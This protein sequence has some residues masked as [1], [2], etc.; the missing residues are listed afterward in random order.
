M[1]LTDPSLAQKFWRRTDIVWKEIF[2]PRSRTT[3]DSCHGLHQFSNSFGE[4]LMSGKWSKASS[5][6]SLSE[7]EDS[8]DS[9]PSS[10]K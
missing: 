8:S 7:L 4:T 3:S 5:S 2:L 10:S 9:Y 1:T 6:E